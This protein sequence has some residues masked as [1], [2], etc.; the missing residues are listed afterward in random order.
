MNKVS[1][2][3]MEHG[4]LWNYPDINIEKPCVECTLLKQW[5]GLEFPDGTDANIDTG[6]WLHHM[7]QFASGPTRWDAVCYSSVSLPHV[8]VFLSP[9]SAERYFSSGN[10]RS[11]YDFNKGGKDMSYGTGYHLTSPDR[12]AFL[13]ELMNTNIGEQDRVYDHDL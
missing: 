10:E 7:V 12:Y 8:A 4:M 11:V 6:M 5:A 1:L 13:V 3:T 9:S 2:P